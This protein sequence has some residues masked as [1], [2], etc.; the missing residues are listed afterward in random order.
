MAAVSGP[1][2]AA[3]C[4]RAEHNMLMTPILIFAAEQLRGHLDRVRQLVIVMSAVV[5]GIQEV[6]RGSGDRVGVDAEVVVQIL[7][8]A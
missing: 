1:R 2:H 6:G 3:G 4:R 8:V 5:C 7:E